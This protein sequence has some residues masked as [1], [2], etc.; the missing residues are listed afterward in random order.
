MPFIA[1]VLLFLLFLGKDARAQRVERKITE[2]TESDGLSSRLIQCLLQD[3]R[4]VLWFGTPDGL[5]YYDSYNFNVLRKSSTD[6]NSISSNY[7]TKLAEDK[8]VDIWIGYLYGGVSRYNIATGRFRHFPLKRDTTSDR[9]GE[10]TMLFIDHLNQVWIGV[11]HEGLYLLD[12][13]TG[14]YR[15]YPL[16]GSDGQP[17]AATLGAG[18]NTVYAAREGSNGLLWLATRAGLYQFNTANGQMT[19][20]RR[21][22][23]TATAG[24]DEWFQTVARDQQT[25]WLGSRS[26]GLLSYNIDTHQW[27]QYNMIQ[28]GDANTHRIVDLNLQG[29]D[30]IWVLTDNKGPAVFQRSTGKFSFL[31]AADQRTG[32]YKD[33]IRDKANN[34]WVASDRGLLRIWNL[35]RRFSYIPVPIARAPGREQYAVSKVFVNARYQLTGLHNGDGLHLLD[36]RTKQRTTLPF[37]NLPAEDN[38]LQVTDIHEDRQGRI[39]VLTRDYLHRLDPQRKTLTIVQPGLGALSNGLSTHL[40]LLR[41]DAQGRLWIGTRYSGC[42][43]YDADNDQVLAHYAPDATGGRHLPVADIRAIQPDAYGGIWIGGSQ[44]YLGRLARGDR[45]FTT[46]NTG[47]GMSVHVVTGIVA[48]RDGSTW[49]GTDGGL[50]Q[51]KTIDHKPVFQKV[52]TAENGILSD[53]VQS[54][55]AGIDGQI[56]CITQT[57][58]CRLDPRTGIVVNYGTGEGLENPYIGSRIDTTKTGDMII[59]STGGY[60]EFWPSELDIAL[61][62]TQLLITSFTVNGQQRYYGND[63]GSF[64]QIRL[65]PSENQFTFE[66]ASIDFNRVGSQRY[67]YMLEGVDKN[68][69]YTR[70][71]YAGYSNLPAGNYTFRVKAVGGSGQEEGSVESVSIYVAGY[72]YK[73]WW[74]AASVFALFCAVIYIVYRIRLR[75]QRLFYELQT[76]A[77][78]LEKEKAM[79]MYESLK[80]QLNPHFL[81]NSLTSL[82]SL[83]R[84]D[85]NMAG[86]FLDGLSRTYRYILQNRDKELV[87]LGDEVQFSENYLRLQQIRFEEALQVRIRVEEQYH[88]LRIAPVTLQNLL[89]NAIKHNIVTVDEPL[90]MDVFVEQETLIVKNV[91]NK[92]SFVETSNRQGLAQLQSLYQFL[93]QRPVEIIE[94][95]EHFMVKVPLL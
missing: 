7:V 26:G 49:V 35:A 88:H 8:T 77:S 72:F 43:V 79:V 94:T 70:T 37:H 59:T 68:W 20:V 48:G 54:V 21:Q 23:L 28:T 85:A 33:I 61:Y 80:Q 40:Q 12:K 57:A 16:T 27:G 10:I 4:G 56:W 89:E 18:Y 87:P 95:A 46:I 31:E 38:D 66:F 92:K 25:L 9:Q 64:S 14:K 84:I 74:F 52:Y 75:N 81:F 22:P 62:N 5:H 76:K 93:S 34:V 78:L 90:V 36:K 41:E 60:Y 32:Q 29:N 1:C 42:Y 50:L 65:K 39:W 11:Q 17:L 55:V 2:Y 15:N 71:R 30:T 19:T 53:M 63:L 86:E 6:T 13:A 47:L 83:I 24:N 51:Y 58:L 3:S 91:L 69:I 73:T 44:G 82:S 45:S 67:A